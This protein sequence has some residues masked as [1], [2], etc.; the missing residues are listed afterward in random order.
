MNDIKTLKDEIVRAVR[1]QGC[2]C[3]WT[4]I[5]RNGR[6]NAVR[7]FIESPGGVGLEEC[8]KVS[9][10]VGELLDGALGELFSGP[11]NIEVS[12]PGVERP[13]FTAE[14]HARFAGE[15]VA[16]IVKGRGKICGTII[17]ASDGRIT[18]LPD[19]GEQCELEL[20]DIKKANLIYDWDKDKKVG[21]KKG[22][23]RGK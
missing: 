15:R 6:A 18:I 2:E 21:G 14:D 19:G 12:S 17:S 22:K 3:A 13:L 9:R 20:A 8:T 16:L 1:S 11:F 5:R 23:S 10:A 7:V 4:E